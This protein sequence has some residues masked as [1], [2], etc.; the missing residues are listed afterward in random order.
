[1]HS[2]NDNLTRWKKLAGGSD[3]HIRW[4]LM[5]SKVIGCTTEMKSALY[6]Q[7]ESQ[8]NKIKRYCWFQ[9]VKGLDCIARTT[10]SV[11]K[12][13]SESSKSLD[14]LEKPGYMAWVWQGAE[15]C[16]TRADTSTAIGYKTMLRP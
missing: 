11:L 6:V 8:G 14:F 4:D 9:F 7:A 3:H 12:V 5:A 1:M 15:R 13:P 16:G 2:R 10:Y